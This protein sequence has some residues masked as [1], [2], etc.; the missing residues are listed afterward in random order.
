MVAPVKQM[1]PEETE[2]NKKL[3]FIDIRVVDGHTRDCTLM[4]PA[5]G[6]MSFE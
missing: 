5:L 6:H 1:L 4:G 3:Q 2:E